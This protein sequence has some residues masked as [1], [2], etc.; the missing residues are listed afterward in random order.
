[1]FASMGRKVLEQFPPSSLGHDPVAW[2]HDVS[3]YFL[4]ERE[5]SYMI[6]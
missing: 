4:L 2:K 6:V 1:M 3:D 5:L